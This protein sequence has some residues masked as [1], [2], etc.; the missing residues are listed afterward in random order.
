MKINKLILI[1][2]FLLTLLSLTAVSASED[3]SNMTVSEDDSLQADAEVDVLERE[4]FDYEVV[5]PEESLIGDD[6]Q[7]EVHLPSDV[8]G[9][10]EIH[11]DNEPVMSGEASSDNILSL[12]RLDLSFGKHTANI[13][14]SEDLKYE[15]LIIS[16]VFS[17]TQLKVTVPETVKV[18][19]DY[20]DTLDVELPSDAEGSVKV[21]I[22]GELK[23]NEE[24]YGDMFN[25]PF[26][27]L[28]FGMHTYEVQY[29]SKSDEYPS[30]KK[31]GEFGL[32]YNFEIEAGSQGFLGEPFKVRLI[33]PNDVNSQATLS[34]NGVNHTVDITGGTGVIEITDL[35]LGD[36]LIVASFSA[37]KYA[38]KSVNATVTGNPLIDIPTNVSYGDPAQVRIAL[39]GDAA[40]TVTVKLADKTYSQSLKNGKA[41]VQLEDL[42]IG[43][44]GLEV[45]YT[46]SYS[47]LISNYSGSLTV[48]PNLQVPLNMWTN[49]RYS[50]IFKASKDYNSKLVIQSDIFNA[51][52]DVVEGNA[53][54]PLEG[55]PAG[56]YVFKI[57]YEDILSE[58]YDV[59]V[60]AIE[61]DAVDFTFPEEVFK[62][63]PY[64]GPY[65]ELVKSSDEIAGEVNVIVDGEK[66]AIWDLEEDSSFE[67]PAEDLEIGAHTIVLEYLG[68]GYFKA[69]NK[70][71]S[72][73][74]VNVLIT[75]PDPVLIDFADTLYVDLPFDATGKITVKVDGKAFATVTLKEQDDDYTEYISLG[76]LSCGMHTIEATYSGNF[77][78]VTKKATVEVTY[79]IETDMYETYVYGHDSNISYRLPPDAKNK[80]TVKID[81]K[82]YTS[83]LSYG[84]FVVDISGLALGTHKVEITYAGDSRYPAKSFTTSFDVIG[85]I[86][87]TTD[88][89]YSQ[90]ADFSVILPKDKK[91]TL[92]LY[93]LVN[94]NY[95]LLESKGL[96]GGN[97][98]I[99]LHNLTPGKYSYKANFT[100]D[101]KMEALFADVNVEPQ[102]ICPESMTV[103]DSEKLIFNPG[104]SGNLV[105][106]ADGDELC[107]IDIDRAAEVSLEDLDIKS[108]VKIN[109]QFFSSA[110]SSGVYEKNVYVKV[111]P[112]VPRIT[113]AK[114]VSMYY[115]D[116]TKYSVKIYGVYGKLVGAGEIVSFKIGSKTYKVKTDKKGVASLKITDLPKKYTIT[117]SYKNVK[118]SKKLTVKQILTLKA[119]KVKKSAKKLVLTATLKK[120]KTALKSKKLTF[121]FNGK[122]F[123]AKTSKKGIAK[124]TIKKS[125]LKKL[126][127]G[128]KI[129]YQVTYLKDTV[130]RTAKV[131]K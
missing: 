86:V 16:R 63:S 107:D 32:D 84:E 18:M 8:S 44:F 122:K 21:F 49:G 53:V 7:I 5:V 92:F 56:D 61:D 28:S 79:T 60:Y 62:N 116:G 55:L 127:A 121:K 11:I 113:N 128:K 19:G 25:F 23:Y 36:N 76:S 124:V 17:Y 73:K 78:A 31:T 42:E 131:S 123:Y 15:D 6:D 85:E 46:G 54:I 13:Y 125:V 96:S 105:V 103:G 114:D 99:S 97:A 26:E 64:G 39:P 35:K 112:Y 74:V 41:T 30:V 65:I 22:D 43:E 94:N 51:S 68:N 98:T 72:F 95:V 102:I 52:V 75:I 70:T 81:G 88:I 1:S 2:L 33:L 109:I 48:V 9:N 91:G 120:G 126:K 119:V 14:F 77:P 106:T 130:K 71:I 110:F 67:L 57:S 66:L 117:V 83:I 12:D 20:G 29:I 87:A 45:N 27:E 104:V 115:Y 34:V 82:K 50:I 24:Y 89:V 4:E 58:S 118:V 129:T 100:G 80:A 38:P 111:N 101:Y 108:R 69:F 10:L 40:G 47:D 3:L 37:D 93:T 90:S 59:K